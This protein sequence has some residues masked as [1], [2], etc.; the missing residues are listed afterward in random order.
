MEDSY[1]EIFEEAMICENLREIAELY[2]ITDKHSVIKLWN[3]TTDRI[4]SLCNKIS[5]EERELATTIMNAATLVRESFDNDGY[6]QYILQMQLIPGMMRYL[7]RYGSIDVDDGYWSICGTPSGFVSL[8]CLE[9]EM[10][11]HSAYD[12]M[13]EAYLLAKNLYE[14]GKRDFWFFGCGLG[15]LPY[16]MWKISGGSVRVHICEYKSEMIE[17]AGLFGPLDLIDKDML[18]IRLFP[19]FA[20]LVNEYTSLISGEHK[21]D[22]FPSGYFQSM[23]QR[24]YG[25]RMDSWFAV[26]RTAIVSRQIWSINKSFNSE[27]VRQTHLDIP[28]DMLRSEWLVVAAGPSFDENID[29]LKES[30]GKRTVIAVSTVIPRLERE[31]IRPDLLIVCD[32]Y[33]SIYPHI[34]GH[35]EFTEGIPLIA[36]AQTYWKFIKSYRGP[37]YLMAQA[38]DEPD[39]GVEYPV[40][41]S[42]GTVT[43]M[44]I[45]A[46]CLMGAE[47]V[48][49]MGMD[50]AYPGGTRYS[51]GM[52]N[53]DDPETEALPL[54][55]SNDGSMVYSAVNFLLY[56]DQI[57][58]Q[59]QYHSDIEIWNLSGHGLYIPLMRTGK[60]WEEGPGEDRLSWIDNISRDEFLNWREKYYLLRQLIDT[61]GVELTDEE[62]EKARSLVLGLA[63]EMITEIGL[64]TEKCLKRGNNI[65]VIIASSTDEDS[66]FS[67]FGYLEKHSMA[68][69]AALIINT[70]ER[71]SGEKV[72]L[73]GAAARSR[74]PALPANG[75]ITHRGQQY[76]YFQIADKITSDDQYREIA[77]ILAGQNGINIHVV[78]K[79][80]LFGAWIAKM[81][82]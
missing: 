1:R 14:T 58:E 39:S 12:P 11:L 34:K 69:K 25:D 78:D 55:R 59:V 52:N 9:N 30:A 80:S 37:V 4:V 44:A 49:V 8:K 38:G 73:K 7:E 18:D 64:P 46:A 20:S 68:G 65:E 81:I 53:Q 82:G 50:L 2:A 13:N 70:R 77:G 35:E 48:Y 63:D 61:P 57:R 45:E 3:E 71:L 66:R 56:S 74:T 28:S 32:P 24:E 47:R 6:I 72:Y 5:A 40:W 31:G 60:W 29:F 26:Y 67:A 75:T 15:Y 23:V 41:N 10:Y 21:Y 62:N 17:Y 16:Q 76:A 19:D 33:D 54:A 79:F 22:A 36:H 27:A 43:S 42:G 51:K